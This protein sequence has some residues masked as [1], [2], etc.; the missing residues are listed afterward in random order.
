MPLHGQKLP[1]LRAFSSEVGNRF[2]LVCRR[3]RRSHSFSECRIPR[4][5]LVRGMRSTRR[6]RLVHGVVIRVAFPER[7]V[8]RRDASIRAVVTRAAGGARLVQCVVAGVAFSER[9]VPRRHALAGGLRHRTG[10]K[11]RAE[12]NSQKKLLHDLLRGLS[13]AQNGVMRGFGPAFLSSFLAGVPESFVA[14]YF[15]SSCFNGSSIGCSR[16]DAAPSSGVPRV[17]QRLSACG[18]CRPRVS[19]QPD[20]PVSKRK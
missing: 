4:R 15:S 9:R 2:V 6:A 17:T 20:K 11:H 13:V 10:R 14:L 1:R 3:C 7:R 12:R 16:G 8:P 19:T 5:D 18:L